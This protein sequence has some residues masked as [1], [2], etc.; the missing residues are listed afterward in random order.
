MN[1]KEII[2]KYLTD[3]GYDGLVEPNTECGCS[4]ED[5]CLGEWCNDC[6]P[7]YAHKNAKGEIVYSRANEHW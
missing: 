2:Q 4:I 3:N 6:E 1:I 5:I 7:A